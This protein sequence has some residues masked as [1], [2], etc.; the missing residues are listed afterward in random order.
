M[1]MAAWKVCL[2]GHH[3]RASLTVMPDE[4]LGAL[5][6]VSWADFVLLNAL[7]VAGGSLSTA[8][9]ALSLGCRVRGYLIAMRTA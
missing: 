3:R 7:D 6:G 2:D 8:A 9:L 1:T 5:H 4:K